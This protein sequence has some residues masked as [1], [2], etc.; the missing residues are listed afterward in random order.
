MD[1]LLELVEVPRWV[2]YFGM[3]CW[4]YIAVKPL[5][6]KNKKYNV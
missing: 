1:Y 4:I 6:I 5:Y 3:L 2:Y